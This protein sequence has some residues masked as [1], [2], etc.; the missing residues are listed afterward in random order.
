MNG[1]FYMQI[2]GCVL[3]TAI[4]VL[5]VCAAIWFSMLLYYDIIEKRDLRRWKKRTTGDK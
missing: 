5:A 2:L 1:E 3:I 4:A